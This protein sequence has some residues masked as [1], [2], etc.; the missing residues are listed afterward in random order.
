MQTEKKIIN[1][2]SIKKT[3]FEKVV[4]TYLIDISDVIIV[5]SPKMNIKIL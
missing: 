1:G 2:K 5:I 3:L 4:P